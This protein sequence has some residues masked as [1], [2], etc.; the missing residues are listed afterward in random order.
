MYN[1]TLV[2]PAK[3]EEL[4][5]P[6]VL[7]ELKKYRLNAIIV[8][9]TFNPT[10]KRLKQKFNC[11]IFKQK[12]RGYGN[13]ILEGIKKVKTKNLCIFNADGSFDPRYI[14]KMIEFI[15]KKNDFIFASRYKKGG[16]SDDDTLLTFVGNKFFTFLGNFFFNIKISDILFT[17]IIGKTSS[18]KKLKLISD[19]FR[20]CVEIPL[21]IVKKNM[22]YG[23]I[24][25]YERKRIAG[26]KNVNEFKDGFL[27]LSYLVKA[28]FIKM[29]KK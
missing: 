3:N 2:I 10:I 13:A 19:D 18:F 27:I 14:Q 7:V 8:V 17:Y 29:Y 21:N 23:D 4:C 16:G 26:K 1:L 5:L 20:L 12:K 6:K 11:K 15:D 22:S 9:N 25:V 24:A 28:F